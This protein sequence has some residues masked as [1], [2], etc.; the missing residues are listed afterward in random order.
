MKKIFLYALAA[1]VMAAC[2]NNSTTKDDHADQMMHDHEMTGMD[3]ASNMNTGNGVKMVMA[4]FT[5]VDAGVTSYMKTLLN[6]YLE[7]K[8]ALAS[9]NASGAASASGK[10][11]AAMKSFDKS[12]LTADQKKE[13]DDIEDDLKEQAEHISENNA[14]EHKRSHF[15]MMSEDLYDMAK[16][17]GAGMTLYHDHC[18]MYNNGSMWLS[19]TKEIRNP[20]YGSKMPT[21]GSVEE[22]FQ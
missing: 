22:M 19:E 6:N 17:F 8:N 15:S 4:S 21:C 18:P 14:I 16:A 3:S 12:L 2:N 11:Y 13:Y 7:I 1:T 5:N 9:D 10:M 20:Y